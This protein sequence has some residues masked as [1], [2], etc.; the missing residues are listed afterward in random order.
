MVQLSNFI[1]NYLG[2]EWFYR[3]WIKL[4]MLGLKYKKLQNVKN[5]N[6]NENGKDDNDDYGD[7]KENDN[8]N[9]NK[10]PTPTPT[11]QHS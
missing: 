1:K 3:R 7:G 6:D 9:N 5:N 2:Q 10:T 11:L 4:R 8:D